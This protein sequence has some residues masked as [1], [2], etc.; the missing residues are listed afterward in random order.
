MKTIVACVAAS[1]ML[2]G[3]GL[4]AFDRVAPGGIV[5]LIGLNAA[6]WTEYWT[7]HKGHTREGA[8]R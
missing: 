8:S 7:E 4:L 1:L 5:F 6:I 2:C 3:L